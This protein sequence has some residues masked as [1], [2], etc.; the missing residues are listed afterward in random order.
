MAMKQEIDCWTSLSSTHG[1]GEGDLQSS[2]EH[3]EGN[4]CIKREGEV[5][6]ERCLAIPG[7]DGLRDEGQL[8]LTQD[9]MVFTLKQEVST[10]MFEILSSTE[11][12]DPST[13]QG[14]KTATITEE[15][16]DSRHQGTVE[17]IVRSRINYDEEPRVGMVVHMGSKRS[18]NQ[19]C[20]PPTK[21]QR[22]QVQQPEEETTLYQ[23]QEE[24][25]PELPSKDE[26]EV[27]IVITVTL[28]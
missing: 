4:I 11:V 27:V 2:H 1:E 23:Q 28:N 26:C 12:Q 10:D 25:T 14:Y 13:D 15:R 7:S 17:T 20:V 22:V 18:Q 16:L 21:K 6:K 8:V 9:G 24:K 5:E 19:A 3:D